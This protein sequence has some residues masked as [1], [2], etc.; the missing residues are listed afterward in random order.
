VDVRSHDFVGGNINGVFNCKFEEL[1]QCMPKLLLQCESACD[2]IFHCMYSQHRAPRCAVKYWKSRRQWER[3][4]K[5]L[6][7]QRVWVLEGGFKKWL[8]SFVKDSTLVRNF[9][10]SYWECQTFPLTGTEY[11]YCNDW[12]PDD[13]N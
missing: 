2:V 8:S 9:E 10:E 11:F 6:H 13:T 12:K 5:L 7:K 4:Y 1:E 3:K